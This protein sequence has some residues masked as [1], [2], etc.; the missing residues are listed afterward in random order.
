MQITHT[1]FEDP[2]RINRR[3]LRELQMAQ[4]NLEHA[5]KALHQAAD[6]QYCL[7]WCLRHVRK[8]IWLADLQGQMLYNSLN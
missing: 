4:Q 1:Q 6:R 8:A 7:K 5:Q 3:I 2:G